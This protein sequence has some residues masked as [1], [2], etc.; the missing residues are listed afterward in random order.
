MLSLPKRCS[1]V[2]LI[3]HVICQAQN[4]P[5]APAL[6]EGRGSRRQ[7]CTFDEL[8]ARSAQLAMQLR[9]GGL[10]PGDTVLV[11]EPFSVGLY[12]VLAALFRAGLV[13][14]VPDPSADRARLAACCRTCAPKGF[15]GPPKA[16]LLRLLLPEVRA[17]PQAFATGRWPVPGAARLRLNHDGHGGDA[18]RDEAAVVAPRGDDAPA[19][20][21]FTSGSTG[22][23]K[24]VVRTHGLLLHQYGALREA[25]ALQPGQ[26]DFTTLPIFALANLAAG[27]TSVLPV[28]DLPAPGR[29]R[30]TAVLAQMRAEHAAGPLHRL[31]AS[32][33]FAER[34]LQAGG[35]DV[36]APLTRIAL[37]GAPVPPALLHRLQQE[38][39]ADGHRVAVYGSTEAEPIA[40]VAAHAVAS[41]DRQATRDGRGLLVGPPVAA[42]EVRI[43]PDRW[44]EPIGPFSEEAFEAYVQPPGQ[45]GEIV[46][47]GPHVV[48][49]YLN[50]Q[51]DAEAKFEVASSR[52]HRTGDAG[53]FDAEGRL[54]LLGRCSAKVEDPHGR[55]YP[56]TVTS[57]ARAVEGVARAA[58]SPHRGQRVL[59][60]E[61]ERSQASLDALEATLRERLAWAHL[62][63]VH[64]TSTLPTD[65]R[66]H[67]KVD[68]PALHRLL[69][70]ER[71]S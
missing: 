54:W 69:D 6:I 40:H 64:F 50:G 19:L 13:A 34:L 60:V 12:I 28:A 44:G 48:P 56:L 8:N 5:E 27:V 20:L 65:R 7:V 46:V 16:H 45:P 61:P 22:R 25:L 21:T 17:I 35:D 67:A 47:R 41:A 49:G 53:R 30:T 42:V 10:A 11:A 18:S 24:A 4:R 32:P 1:P 3:H 39:P 33:A 51:G 23:P 57:A 59:V 62:D 66:H 58:F 38:A 37:G 36:L 68:Y 29:R 52:W 14:M 71:P 43:L 31:A 63:A 15:V 26:R 2:N 70:E 9:A 55:C